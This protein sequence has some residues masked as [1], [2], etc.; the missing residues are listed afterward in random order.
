VGLIYSGIDYAAFDL[1][2]TLFDTRTG[3]V[4]VLTHECDVD[5]NNQREYNDFVLVAPVIPSL[6]IIQSLKEARSEVYARRAAID[7]VN[8]SVSRVFF[9]PPIPAHVSDTTLEYGGFVFMN[10]ISHS[11]VSAFSRPNAEARCALSETGLRAFDAK[12]QHHLLRPKEQPLP[13]YR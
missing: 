12:L 4:L 13:R 11:H 1:E 2:S 5:Q 3:L 6:M 9:L 8:N 7:L 10:Q